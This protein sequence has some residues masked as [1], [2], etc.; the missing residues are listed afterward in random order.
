MK[1]IKVGDKLIPDDEFIAYSGTSEFEVLEVK[2]FKSDLFIGGIGLDITLGGNIPIHMAHGDSR[3]YR[4]IKTI[5]HKVNPEP[6]VSKN[7][8]LHGKY[9]RAIFFTSEEQKQQWTK[10][11][12][13]MKMNNYLHLAR[14]Y[15]Y[16]G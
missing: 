14:K 12:R 7:W 6:H 11:Y 4:T 15:G 3:E 2:E 9:C 10:R 1:D 8:N 13:E 16:E 5:D